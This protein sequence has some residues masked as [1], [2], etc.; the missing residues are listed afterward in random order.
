MLKKRPKTLKKDDPEQSRL[1][2]EKAREIEADNR[3]AS[4]ADKLI[5]HLHSQPHVPHKPKSRR[6]GQ[7]R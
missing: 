5:G 6:K 7:A 1:F 2:I 3:N 4:L